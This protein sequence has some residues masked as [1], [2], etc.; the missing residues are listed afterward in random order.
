[1][2]TFYDELDVFCLS[3][4]R[5][6]LPNV[7]LEAMAMMCPVVATSVGGLSTFLRHDVDALLC[8]PGSPTALADALR[9][10]IGSPELRLRLADQARRRVEADGS[11]D[12]RMSRLFAV[13]ER[14][15]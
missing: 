2:R 14:L 12:R 9:T 3:S 1:M 13:Y 10:A 15:R 6:G 5:E 7:V 11:L 4:L 8:P